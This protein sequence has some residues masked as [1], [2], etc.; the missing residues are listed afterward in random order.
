MTTAA[1][2]HSG[3][4]MVWCR[5]CE[6]KH[7]ASIPAMTFRCHFCGWGQQNYRDGLRHLIDCPG[8]AIMAVRHPVSELEHDA[9][10]CCRT[11]GTHV[12]PHNGCT[13]S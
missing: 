11:C 13:L 3:E 9:S 7:V 8:H 2:D 6:T 12:I 5:N 1:H 10:K 4:H